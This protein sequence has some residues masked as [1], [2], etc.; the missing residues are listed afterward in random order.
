MARR[1]GP[2]L[3]QKRSK[4][5]EKEETRSSIRWLATENSLQKFFPFFQEIWLGVRPQQMQCFL[6]N[7]GVSSIRHIMFILLDQSWWEK[8]RS[9]SKSTGLWGSFVLL[10]CKHGSN[11]HCSTD[12]CQFRSYLIHRFLVKSLGINRPPTSKCEGKGEKKKSIRSYIIS[13]Q[14]FLEKNLSFEVLYSLP[15]KFIRRVHGWLLVVIGFAGNAQM[16]TGNSDAIHPV[17]FHWINNLHPLNRSFFQ[18]SALKTWTK[19]RSI[20]FP[21]PIGSNPS[22]CHRM[23]SKTI[24][25]VPM[26]SY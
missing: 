6:A 3:R 21:P 7:H 22:P 4:L 11:N 16:P 17:A 2:F 5:S 1:S 24:G 14:F 9:L 10:A 26:P 12:W 19:N 15:T 25:F 18:L 13:R 8:V 23:T 20:P